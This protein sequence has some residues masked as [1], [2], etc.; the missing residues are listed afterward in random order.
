ML[1]C[2]M[3]GRR[4]LCRS[5][6]YGHQHKTCSYFVNRDKKHRFFVTVDV[7]VKLYIRCGNARSFLGVIDNKYLIV[8]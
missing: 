1:L 4:Y 8:S 2:M 5:D 7:F 6:V 3:S